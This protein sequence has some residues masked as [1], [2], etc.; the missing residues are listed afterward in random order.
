MRSFIIIVLFSLVQLS[1]M[2]HSGK[3]Q[4]HIIVD[5]DGALDDMRALTM[6]LAAN[7]VRVLAISGSRGTVSAEESADKVVCLLQALHH[8][9]IPLAVGRETDFPLPQWYKFASKIN[10]GKSNDLITKK[11]EKSTELLHRT[12]LT[13][14]Y[15][16]T[17][18]AL[19]SLTTYSDWLQAYPED[20]A[21]IERIIWYN[22]S[23][24]QKSFNYLIDTSAFNT[25]R[26]MSVSVHI[27]SNQDRD[28]I[29]NRACLDHLKTVSSVYAQHLCEVH[30]QPIVQKRLASDHPLLL[31]DD[32]VS[33]YLTVPV[34]FNTK[35]Q[36]GITWVEINKPPLTADII[37][38]LMGKLLLSSTISNNRVFMDFPRDSS[39]YKPPIAAIMPET[40]EKY[41]RVEWKALVMTNEVHGHTGIYSIIGAKM[42][43]RACEYFNVGVNNLIV[44]TYAG[45]KPP[46]SC[47]NDGIQISTG[48]TIGQGLI[49]VADSVSTIPMADFTCNQKTVRIQLNEKIA[50][51]MQEQISYGVQEYGLLTD[52][53][54]LYIEELAIEY[55]AKYDR[56]EIFDIKE[57]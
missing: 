15:P 40:L 9:G 47:F 4:Y 24:L 10:W 33:L 27:V 44:K 7:D 48:A 54:W 3:P 6:L 14:K 26:Q 51:E 1:A 55:W 17:L 23:N 20:S 18:I 11:K 39:L 57:F 45:R 21:K 32:L 29:C 56:H 13:Y 5:T 16:V 53:Y 12:L 49:S 8:E 25:I 50:R 22:H 28:L 36:D 41:G 30:S 46:L 31:W 43:I 42:G 19:G 34:L 35:K 38:Q 2:A 37:H 52:R